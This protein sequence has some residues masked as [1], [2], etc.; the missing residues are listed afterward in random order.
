MA[1][2]AR[3]GNRTAGAATIAGDEDT[4]TERLTT[5]YRRLLN[6]VSPAAQKIGS[7]EP[8]KPAGCAGCLNP[9]TL[10]KLIMILLLV[11]FI[12]VFLLP[13]MLV[14]AVRSGPKALRYTSAFDMSSGMAARFGHGALHSFVVSTRQYRLCV[15]PK[16]APTRQ[17][18]QLLP[19]L[20]QGGLPTA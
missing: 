8:G 19:L 12:P 2:D 20:H 7:D 15:V 14:W 3:G 6:W 9:I 13:M 17:P 5:I 1:G 10:V 4:F 18:F 11:V 16:H